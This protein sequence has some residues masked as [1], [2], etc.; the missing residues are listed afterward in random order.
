MWACGA[1]RAALAPYETTVPYV[2]VSTP[3]PRPPRF[4]TVRRD[5]GP[6]RDFVLEDPRLGINVW[7]TSE[8][9]VTDLARTVSAVFRASAGG[10]VTAVRQMS[11]P[12]PIPD[13]QPRRYMTFQLTV[14]GDDLEAPTP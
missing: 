3:N 2:G 7:G 4:V 10:V 9:D 12:S 6:V 8:Q 5:G 1:I 13:A 14:R 11:G